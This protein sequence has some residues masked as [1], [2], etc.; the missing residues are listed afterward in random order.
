MSAYKKIR[1]ASAAE[2][3][4]SLDS[5]LDKHLN[6]TKLKF[7]EAKGLIGKDLH[8][9][10]QSRY[11]IE[12]I[13]YNIFD[14]ISMEMLDECTND[15]SLSLPMFSGCSDLSKF[16]SQPKR[17]VDALHFYCLK[18]N[19]VI[20]ST[21]GE[22]VE[23]VDELVT[24]LSGWITMLPSHLITEQGLQCV[25]EL[26]DTNTNIYTHVGDLDVSASYPNGIIVFNISKETTMKELISIEGVNEDTKRMATINLSGGCT[27]AVEI[28]NTI[29]GLPTLDKWLDEC[30]L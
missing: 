26:P 28:C 11:P 8:I 10:M 30:D 9:F 4:Y 17:A 14:C 29:F 2:A 18:N 25:K 15:L 21:S 12:Y 22:M 16:K 20:G 1:I 19:M 6:I 27:N 3:S 13:V 5:I 24:D 7:D 23:D